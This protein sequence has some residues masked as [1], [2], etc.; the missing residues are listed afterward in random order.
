MVI[1]ITVYL[2]SIF[3]V[4]WQKAQYCLKMDR[5]EGHNRLL[6]WQ[7]KLIQAEFEMYITTKNRAR[8]VF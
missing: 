2:N 3:L 5:C 6:C 8:Q 7:M 4:R 1:R